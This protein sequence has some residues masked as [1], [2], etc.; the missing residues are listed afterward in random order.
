MAV[1]TNPPHVPLPSVVSPP[2]VPNLTSFLTGHIG[3]EVGTQ[4][5][6]NG[7]ATDK[8][9]STQEDEHV[10]DNVKSPKKMK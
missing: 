1:N 10:H 3:Q 4:A 7:M 5:A 6:A 2:S 8:G 9:S